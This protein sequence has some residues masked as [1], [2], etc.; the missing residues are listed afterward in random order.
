MTSGE[1]CYPDR[2][3]FRNGP[4]AIV[5]RP[6]C[7]TRCRAEAQRTGRPDIGRAQ[8]RRGHQLREAMVDLV[9]RYHVMPPRCYRGWLSCSIG[10]RRIRSTAVMSGW[11][12]LRTGHLDR[13]RGRARHFDAARSICRTLHERRTRD[14]GDWRRHRAARDLPPIRAQCQFAP[15]W[16]PSTGPAVRNGA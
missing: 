2:L 13:N 16:R 8:F 6:P 15:S 7:Q 3:H 9:N 4:L 12:L 10:P 14:S 1:A 5:R 11:L